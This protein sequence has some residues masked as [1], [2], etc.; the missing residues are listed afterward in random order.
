MRI[1]K[2]I[3]EEKNYIYEKALLIFPSNLK[4]NEGLINNFS[5]Y[6]SVWVYYG[7]PDNT[8]S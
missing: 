5:G 7:N 1:L 8:E 2:S 6:D 4:Y 3:D